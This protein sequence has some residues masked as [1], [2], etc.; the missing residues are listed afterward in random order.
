MDVAFAA[1]LLEEFSRGKI[2]MGNLKPLDKELG[3]WRTPT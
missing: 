2:F 1:N 3:L